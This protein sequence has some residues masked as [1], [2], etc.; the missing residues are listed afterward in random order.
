MV[1][2][3][4][5]V[6]PRQSDGNGRRYDVIEDTAGKSGYDAQR[7]SQD[8]RHQGVRARRPRRVEVDA[9]LFGVVQHYLQEGWSPG[10]IAGILN[11]LWP[12]APAR[13]VAVETIFTCP[14]ALHR[15]IS[16]MLPWA[17]NSGL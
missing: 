8:A 2:R 1:R 5:R 9:A 15:G 11:M 3:L 7:A 13:R 16:K 17:A 4:H 6:P 10:Q 12:D 14:Y